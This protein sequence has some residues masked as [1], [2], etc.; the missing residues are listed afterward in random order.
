MISMPRHPKHMVLNEGVIHA[1]RFLMAVLALLVAAAHLSYAIPSVSPQPSAATAPPHISAGPGSTAV[2]HAGFSLGFSA[3][4]LWLDIEIISY[5]II[6]VVFLLGLRT[7]YLPAVL[8]NAFN[9]CLYFISGISAVPGIT[10]AAF[11]GH[12]DVFS[13]L[14]ATVLVASWISALVLGLAMLKYD[15][16]SELDGLLVTRRLR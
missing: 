8:F 6:A 5:T 3:L 2:T 16:G 4:G 12:L 15:P 11:S 1:A 14:A 10:S 7:W 13:G 9:V